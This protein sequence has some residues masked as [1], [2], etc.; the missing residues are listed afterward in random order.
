MRNQKGFTLLEIMVVLA[1]IAVISALAYPSYQ[2]SARKTRR[3]D[4]MASVLDVSQRL[5]RCYT[6]YGAY[7]NAACPTSTESGKSENEHYEITVD[8][9]TPSTFTVTATP[10][11]EAQKADTKCEEFSIDNTGK[12]TATGTL[13]DDCW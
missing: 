10:I 12:K 3:A 1:I 13:G 2:E 9:P 4:G 6:T 8:T 7:D 11:S 5:E